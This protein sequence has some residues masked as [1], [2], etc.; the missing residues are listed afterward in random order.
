MPLNKRLVERWRRPKHVERSLARPIFKRS[1]LPLL[2]IRPR[3]LLPAPV[4]SSGWSNISGHSP[5]WPWPCCLVPWCG[6]VS[7]VSGSGRMRPL[8]WVSTPMSRHPSVPS[9]GCLLRTTRPRWRR[10]C[11][12]R[13]PSI[14]RRAPTPPCRRATLHQQRRRKRAGLTSAS[15]PMTMAPAITLANGRLTI[16]S[17]GILSLSLVSRAIMSRY[18]ANRPTLRQVM[19]RLSLSMSATNY[20]MRLISMMT[21]LSR[22]CPRRM[23]PRWKPLS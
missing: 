13:L 5:A 21:P 9:Q 17:M 18:T 7:A 1:R 20:D 6:R 22:Q 12:P 14:R 10:Q 19:T 15:Q 11:R 23:R 8:P 4:S 3:A 16:W 2:R